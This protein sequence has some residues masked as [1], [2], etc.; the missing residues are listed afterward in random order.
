MGCARI[1]RNPWRR[2]TARWVVASAGQDAPD[3]EA[4]AD[5]LKRLKGE[6]LSRAGKYVAKVAG[7]DTPEWQ[8]ARVVAVRDLN[9]APHGSATHLREID[10]EIETSR[11]LVSLRN[12]Y[13]AVGKLAQVKVRGGDAVL[14]FPSSGPFPP[15]SQHEPLIRLRGDLR[16]GETK[17]PEEPARVKEVLRVV[18]NKRRDGEQ[19]FN[20]KPDPEQ[21]S[22]FADAATDGSGEDGASA[23]F[24]VEVG[25]FVGTGLNLRGEIQSIFFYRTILLFA[26]GRGI[27]TAKALI[28]S[29]ASASRGGLDFSFREQVKLY[30][31]VKGDDDVCYGQDVFKRWE[32]DYGVKTVVCKGSFSEAIDDDDELEFDPAASA[33][34]SMLDPALS[35]K[36]SKD[37]DGEEENAELI[38]LEKEVDQVCEEWD[39]PMHV[40]SSIS[41]P[42]VI[43]SDTGGVV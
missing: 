18:V 24:E 31:K 20:L 22:L 2:A 36:Q 27:A 17:L 16:A 15:E 7:T 28:E 41:Q 19:V 3:A 4:I 30:Y 11:E 32:T 33:C 39:I 43:Y 26:S 29:S 38:E 40:R 14:L 6:K 34:I 35:D 9:P 37:G 1:G 23:P 10:F 8:P 12:S 13:C 25:P 42:D 21:D 5:E